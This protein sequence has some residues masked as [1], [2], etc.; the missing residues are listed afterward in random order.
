MLRRTL[1]LCL[2]ALCL[3]LMAQAQEA[4]A[5]VD[6]ALLVADS[7]VVTP[8]AELIADGNVEAL[9]EGR[10]L[11]ATQIRYNQ[12][13]DQLVIVGPIRITDTDGTI[14]TAQ[15]AEI[16]A[17]FENGLL[18]GARLVLDRQLQLAAV[19]LAR[20]EGRYS[21]LSRAAVTSCQICGPQGK[22]LWEIRAD[23]IIHD[24]EE[25]Q[26]YLD[27]AQ[28][29]V[30]DVPVVY[31]PRLRFPDPS[32]QRARGFL[33]PTLRS[34]SKLGVGLKTPY[35]IPIGPHRDL[36]L[37]PYVSAQ[38]T[39]IEARYRQAFRNGTIELNGAVTRDSLRSGE[40]R[41]YLFADGTFDLPRDYTLTFDVELTTDEAYLKDYGYSSKNRLDSAIS[42]TKV[43][44]DRLTEGTL[45]HFNTLRD[46]ESN[47]TQPAFVFDASHQQRLFPSYGGELRL[48]AEAHGHFRDSDADIIGR[49]VVR[50]HAEA[51]WQ[52]TGRSAWGV[53]WEAGAGVAIDAVRNRGDSTVPVEDAVVAPHGHVTL[54]MPFVATSGSG[55]RYMLEPVVQLG[56]TGG[57]L[58][59]TGNDES[60]R[61]ELD[62]G[63]LLTLSRFAAK[64]RRERGWQGAAGLRWT[65]V[66]PSGWRTGV[67]VG[68]VVRE[69]DRAAFS[70]TSGLSETR[71][72]WLISGQIGNETGLDFIGRMLIDDDREVHRAE[73]RGTWSNTRLDLAASYLLLPE[74]LDEDR[75]DLVSE[76]SFD[77]AYRVSRHWTASAGW[78]YNLAED[79]SSNGSLG[80]EYQNE[81]VVARFEADR[82]FADSDNLDPTTTFELTVELKGFS[83]GG[84]AGGYRRTCSN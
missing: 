17:A 75:D 30:I 84:D 9:F 34:T 63:N 33:F 31:L 11:T 35:F 42:V 43:T 46:N 21:Q 14:L 68:R 53:L 10:R 57:D 81:C 1:L 38:T 73:A 71:S 26:I 36:T 4:P 55:A 82:D 47:A 78:Q 52:Q 44:R 48:T 66:A 76:W 23:R 27:G 67:A 64:D 37:T 28:L 54:R 60:Q 61:S 45:I 74:D 3:P 80:L 50:T 18:R 65:M 72:D 7:V 16:D 12:D 79:R 69:E 58:L 5:P 51:L 6:P 39:T 83:T 29:R 8:D 62:E 15:S 41:G 2:I 22:P 20:V 40:T 24:D 25:K 70:T 77:G 56:W 59:E 19:Q 13:T 32:L 49:D